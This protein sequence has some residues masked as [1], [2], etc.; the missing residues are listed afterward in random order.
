MP[1]A[2]SEGFDVGG[3]YALGMLAL[4]IA[5]GVGI[6]A[7]SHQQERA[8][9]AA[10]VYVL[11]GALGAVALA[12]L[13]VAPIDPIRD[14]DLLERLTELALVVAVFAAGLTVERHVRRR[15]VV[16]I[17]VLLLVV[18]PLTMAA[19]AAFGY[20]AMGLSLGAAVL[21]GTVLAPTDPVLAGDVGLGPPGSGP[22]GEPRLSLHTEAA[23][24]DGLASPF[25]LIGIFIATQGGT[26]WIGEW[27]WADVLY[28][29]GVAAVL[30]LGMGWGA[31]WLIT[32][33]RE[34]G[35]I[36]AEL[37]ALA[38]LVLVLV[39]YGC[40][41]LAGSY[42]LLA[43]FAAGFAFRRYEFEHELHHGFHRGA[44]TAGTLLELIVLLLLGSMLTREGL[45][46]PGLSGWL[47]APLLILVIR[48][49]LVMATSGPGFAS[50]RE[51][52]F[53]AIFGVRGVAAL[54]YA[55][56][57]AGSGALSPA[58]T[59]VVV[60]TTLVCVVLSI[61]AHGIAATPLTRSLL[62]RPG[63][64]PRSSLPE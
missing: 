36:S 30:G 14:H 59:S 27:L 40:A 47:L 19:I 11:L 12:V 5:L 57:V 29:I 13:D 23:V 39:V 8:F 6:G 24:N 56:I 16:S 4:A 48:P 62:E 51:R 10:V 38:A 34:R 41:E 18:M 42:G 7:L 53:L 32:R 37:D 33:G 17:A 52:L 2:L 31:A 15:S 9:S 49:V 44:E 61:V 46:E 45:G 3:L 58:E 1:V 28:A 43:L 35:L 22:Q 25:V 26:S 60:W 50:L 64:A 54:F 55:A 20:Y 63:Q 21:L